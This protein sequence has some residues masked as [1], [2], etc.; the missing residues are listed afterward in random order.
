MPMQRETPEEQERREHFA[1]GDRYGIPAPYAA[2]E[3]HR[4]DPWDYHFDPWSIYEDRR[5]EVR[6]HWTDDDE[7]YSMD[8]KGE[9]RSVYMPG[10]ER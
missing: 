8:F 6:P 10:M 7:G 4:R 5:A 3:S 1:F 2:P 9:G